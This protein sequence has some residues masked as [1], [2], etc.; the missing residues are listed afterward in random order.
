M[1]REVLHTRCRASQAANK[2]MRDAVRGL[3]Y[4]IGADVRDDPTDRERTRADYTKAHEINPR[5]AVV[6]NNRA[7]SYLQGGQG[8]PRPTR[9][10]ARHKGEH[11]RCT[12]VGA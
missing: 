2:T 9:W 1:A 10:L 3:A 7:W 11:L 4:S 12:G 6:Y 8:C 5:F